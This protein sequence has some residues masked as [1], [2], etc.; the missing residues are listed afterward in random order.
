MGSVSLKLSSFLLFT[1][2]K[3]LFYFTFLKCLSKGHL[4]NRDL[5][6]DTWAQVLSQ[7]LTD[8][9]IMDKSL[10]ALTL[11]FS[12]LKYVHLRGSVEGP[13]RQIYRKKLCKLLSAVF[14]LA[15]YY[16]CPE[17]FLPTPGA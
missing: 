7:Q 10:D 6:Q 16:P 12:H 3:Y 2:K 1:T 14:L 11:K 13:G 17:G 5:N 8:Y 15:V 9:V 4:T